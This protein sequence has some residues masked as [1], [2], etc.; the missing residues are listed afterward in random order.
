M[1]RTRWG[2]RDVQT[3][4]KNS[5]QRILIDIVISVAATKVE[6]Q[7]DGTGRALPNCDMLSGH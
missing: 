7:P 6:I 4:Y 5:E 3:R 1:L 2:L